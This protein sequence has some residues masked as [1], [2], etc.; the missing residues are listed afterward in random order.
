MTSINKK[1]H[2]KKSLQAELEKNEFLLNETG[3]MARVGGWEYDIA[4]GQVFWNKEVYAICNLPETNEIGLDNALAFYP[5][6]YASIL[7]QA[8]QKAIELKEHYDLEIQLQRTSGELIWVRTIG[9]PVLNAKGTVVALRG[10]IQDI[11]QEKRK[12]IE[13]QESSNIIAAQNKRLLNFAYIVSHNLRS[14]AGNLTSLLELVKATDNE[15]ERQVYMSTLYKL[16]E[17]LS[18]SIKHLSEVVKMQTD[19][20]TLKSNILFEDIFDDTVSILAPTI[21]ETNTI[22]DADFIACPYI[23]TVPAYMESIMLNLLSNAIKYKHPDRNPE[24]IIRSAIQGTAK[25]LTVEDNGLGIDL[26]KHR[27]QLFGM[28]KTFH[29]N[30][31]ARGIG[32][33]I[34]KNQIEALGGA[35]EVESKVNQGTKFTIRF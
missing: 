22:I 19:V 12:R 24:I 26:H 5:E 28:Y 14:H 16:G 10:T 30:A 3:K 25:Y 1:T 27:D 21:A 34:T 23:E 9:K 11:D 2:N 17:S 29:N 13:L 7:Q 8:V 15:T 35:I 18:L 4:S 6:P 33:F 31:D 32:L 20:K